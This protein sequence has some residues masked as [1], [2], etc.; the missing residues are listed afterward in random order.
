MWNF[1]QNTLHTL[2]CCCYFAVNARGGRE[3]FELEIRTHNSD[4]IQV[5][6]E[7]NS[8]SVWESVEHTWENLGRGER[9][10][11][12]HTFGL[13]FIFKVVFL[14]MSMRVECFTLIH[15]QKTANYYYDLEGGA[16]KFRNSNDGSWQRFNCCRRR[17]LPWKKDETLCHKLMNENDYGLSMK[18][19]G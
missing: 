15:T 10:S 6:V 18:L 4:F 11:L 13:I 12:S 14:M 9:A 7:W 1:S 16:M 19:K 2:S 17:V 5:N 3:K 8:F